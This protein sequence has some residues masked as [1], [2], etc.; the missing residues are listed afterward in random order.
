MFLIFPE[1]ISLFHRRNILPAP[2]CVY[3]YLPSGTFQYYHQI[4]IATLSPTLD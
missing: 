4:S 2:P 3:G 1:Y